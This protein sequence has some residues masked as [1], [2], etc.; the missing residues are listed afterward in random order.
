MQF[1]CVL[2]AGQK[3]CINFAV[4]KN[5]NATIWF[6]FADKLRENNNT[7]INIIQNC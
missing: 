1:V 3:Y 6:L 5:K 2:F 7:I 4:S